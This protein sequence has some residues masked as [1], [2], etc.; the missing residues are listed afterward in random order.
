M[1][2]LLENKCLVRLISSDLCCHNSAADTLMLVENKYLVGSGDIMVTL[3]L[4]P[5]LM[6]TLILLEDKHLVGLS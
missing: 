2:M 6:D 5:P 1:L 4:L 3:Y